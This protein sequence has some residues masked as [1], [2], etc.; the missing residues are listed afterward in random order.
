MSD[1]LLRRYTAL[2]RE[3]LIPVASQLEQLIRGYLEG[4]PR[5]DRVSAR[6]KAPE[7][8]MAKARKSG[9]GGKSKYP[10]PLEQLQDQ[11]GARVIVLYKRDVDIVSEVVKR[12]FRHIEARVIVPESDWTFGY[13]GTHFVLSLPHDAVPPHIE[14]ERA[15]SFFELQI[16]TLWEH[17]WSEAGHDLGYKPPDQLTDDQQRRLAF[18]A[19]QAWGADRTFQELFEEL[20]ADA[21]T[22]R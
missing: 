7:S 1:E 15:P 17:A 6:A 3:V 14:V 16:K 8:F 4:T 10:A 13:F 18:T 20:V 22:A 9:E 19:A 2:Y 21:G 5:I 12:Y 11:L